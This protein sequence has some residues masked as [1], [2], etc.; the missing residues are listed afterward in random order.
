MFPII[1]K[2]KSNMLALLSLIRPDKIVISAYIEKEKGFFSHNNWGDDINLFFLEEITSRKIIVKNSTFLSKKLP[3]KSVSCIGSIIGF[4]DDKYL[5]VWGSGLLG[6]DYIK[7]IKNGIANTNRNECIKLGNIFSVRGKL[8]RDVLISN[9]FECPPI[10]GDPALL[11]SRFYFPSIEK[12]YKLGI[13]LHYVDENNQVVLEYEKQHAD[14]LIIKMRGYNDWHE[15][16]IKILSCSRILSSSL[17]GLIVSDSYGIPNSWARFSEN[18]SGGSFKFLDYFSSVN[19]NIESPFII[20]SKHD[21]ANIKEK[22]L[23]TVAENID[24]NSIIEA[25]PFRKYI[26]NRNDVTFDKQM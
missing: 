7:G 8:T 9:G 1:T 15:I 10:Y 14:V 24:F 4:F 12:K 25:C 13:I 2:L 26:K 3:I 18:I 16:P 5:N 19:R 21:I 23:F 6:P 17:H 11:L 22:D 20:T